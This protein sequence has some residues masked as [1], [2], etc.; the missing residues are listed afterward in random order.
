MPDLL[1]NHNFNS[2]QT[3]E[4]AA[5]LLDSIFHQLR[6]ILAANPTLLAT[7]DSREPDPSHKA[8]DFMADYA[9]GEVKLKMS[10][11]ENLNQ[12]N[13][14]ALA[15]PLDPSVHGNLAGGSLHALADGSN[16][17]F[18]SASDFTKLANLNNFDG[19]FVQSSEPSLSTNN[20]WAVWI[21][22]S[23]GEGWFLFKTSALG[24]TKIGPSS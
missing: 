9:S 14:N 3:W 8:G 24:Q 6:D 2:I 23:S 21:D 15:G 12:I 17:G 10:D 19:L 16:A 20:H 11:G 18:L 4:E 5:P 13:V 7:V 22:S 1:I